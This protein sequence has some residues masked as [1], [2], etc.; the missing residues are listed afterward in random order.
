MVFDF[1]MKPFIAFGCKND[2]L[3]FGDTLSP[4]LDLSLPLLSSR[5]TAA[6]N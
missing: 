3:F 4:F 6:D 2:D 5:I 1:K